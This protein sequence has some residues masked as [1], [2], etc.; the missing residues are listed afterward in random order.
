VR[1]SAMRRCLKGLGGFPTSTDGFILGP[2][3]GTV[4]RLCC[5][6]SVIP[7]KRSWRGDL[8]ELLV[9]PNVP[10]FLRGGGISSLNGLRSASQWS[11]FHR[12]IGTLPIPARLIK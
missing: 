1:R 11:L 10:G 8:R 7:R 3:H 6:C 2:S 4:G 5:F 9:I 12:R